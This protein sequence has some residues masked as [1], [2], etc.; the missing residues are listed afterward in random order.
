[1]EILILLTQTTVLLLMMLTG[2][3]AFKVAWMDV[4]GWKTLNKLLLNILNPCLLLSIVTSL[5]ETF[6]R[7]IVLQNLLLSILYQAF[8]IGMPVLY[9]RVRRLNGRKEELHKLL[10]TFS[11]NGFMGLPLIRA[12]YGD[13]Y[14]FFLLFY[15]VEF[16][17][18]SY[19]YGVYLATP[20]G[21]GK[22][23]PS[24]LLNVGTVSAA[25]AIL[26]Y[27]LGIPI[28]A[29]VNS[30]FSSVGN[31]VVPL[32]MI[33]IG[34]SLAQ[35]DLKKVFGDKESYIL[36]AVKLLLFPA[37]VA[38]IAAFL[39]FER[40]LTGVFMLCAS[41][42]IAGM[43]G[44]FAEVYGGDGKDCN[45]TIAMTTIFSAFTIPVMFGFYKML[46]P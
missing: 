14:A 41:M 42:P 4:P 3:A 7:S 19:T 20:G 24:G 6:D 34:G 37:A 40:K 36:T 28:A 21:R 2:Y 12:L 43:S 39:P 29:P 17:L 13:S 33:V 30:F 5:Q 1:M 22:F 27:L 45:G 32:S 9:A 25:A 10:L 31:A 15:L 46:C 18:I 38:V 44:M 23:E 11:N 8:F 26:V 35:Q 16:N